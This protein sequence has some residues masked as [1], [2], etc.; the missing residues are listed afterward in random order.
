MFPRGPVG[1]GELAVALSEVLHEI[2]HDVLRAQPF[3]DGEDEVC[4]SN[5]LPEVSGQLNPEHPG[6]GH[7]VRLSEHHR[8]CFYAPDAPSQ[9]AEPIDHGGVRVGPHERVWKCA[10]L[11]GAVVHG[12]DPR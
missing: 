9:H 10:E 4:R 1:H 7:G 2:T 11:S 12:D 8:F 6:N 3:C 5:T